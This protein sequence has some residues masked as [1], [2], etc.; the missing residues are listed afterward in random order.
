MSNLMT[1]KKLEKSNAP[2]TSRM[3][4]IAAEKI[5]AE[6]EAADRN[7]SHYATALLNGDVSIG[8]LFDRPIDAKVR[9]RVYRLLELS[10]QIRGH[11]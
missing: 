5:V 3:L 4:D 10:E 11:E 9:Q 7:G 6:I 8:D 2:P 1:K